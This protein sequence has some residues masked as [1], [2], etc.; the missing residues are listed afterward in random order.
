MGCWWCVRREVGV[1]L[2][3][4]E[5]APETLV[6]KTPEIRAR[7]PGR[8]WGG[9]KSGAAQSVCEKNPVNTRAEGAHQLQVSWVVLT[10]ADP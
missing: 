8:A 3:A 1:E 5:W 2:L 7:V 10:A 9:A 6:L 4:I